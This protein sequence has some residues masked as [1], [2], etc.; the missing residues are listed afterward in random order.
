MTASGKS[1]SHAKPETIMA[2]AQTGAWLRAGFGIRH[3][4]AQGWRYYVRGPGSV[5][6]TGWHRSVADV[7]PASH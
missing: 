2:V 5:H 6:M 1:R 7:T 3:T 4:R